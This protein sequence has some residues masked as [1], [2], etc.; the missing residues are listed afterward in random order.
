MKKTY[1]EVR[2]FKWKEDEISVSL[3]ASSASYGGGV[4]C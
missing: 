3:R 2:F 1:T 4:K